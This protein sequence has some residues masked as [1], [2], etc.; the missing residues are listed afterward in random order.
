[1]LLVGDSVH[2][3]VEMVFSVDHYHLCI[4]VFPFLQYN[5][6]MEGAGFRLLL[7]L[8]NLKKIAD[9]DGVSDVL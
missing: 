4:V 1:M 5:S 6:R 9:S 7:T 8:K 2:L 3:T